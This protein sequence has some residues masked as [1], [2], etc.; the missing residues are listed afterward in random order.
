MTHGTRK[1]MFE[2][3]LFLLPTKWGKTSFWSGWGRAQML[4]QS[5]FLLVG[6][7][8]KGQ[9]FELDQSREKVPFPKCPPGLAPRENQEDISLTVNFT[10]QID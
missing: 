9:H 10:C 8:A 6:D 2:H 4:T 1:Q 5:P 3:H 7:E